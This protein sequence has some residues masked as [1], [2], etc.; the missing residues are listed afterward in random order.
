MDVALAPGDHANLAAPAYALL[1]ATISCFE[2]R[3]PTPTVAVLLPTYVEHDEEGDQYLG[4]GAAV[5]HYIERLDTGSLIHLQQVAPWL[6]PASTRTSGIR[7]LAHHC[8]SCGAVQGDHFVFSPDGPYFPQDEAGVAR[9]RVVA[10][11]GPLRAR[12]SA[13][14]SSWMDNVL[15]PEP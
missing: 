9:L 4:D 11:V 8:E 10:G 5:L 3:V 1:L 13:A 14:M 2:C 7:Y 12:A 15:L 6:Y